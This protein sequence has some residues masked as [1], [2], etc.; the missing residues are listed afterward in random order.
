MKI[1][2]CPNCRGKTLYKSKETSSGG[3]HAPNY[4][5]GL[6]KGLKSGRFEVVLCRDCGLARFFATSESLKKVSDSGKW[7]RVVPSN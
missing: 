1:S 4:L 5:P 6:G 2:P 7:S 3:G